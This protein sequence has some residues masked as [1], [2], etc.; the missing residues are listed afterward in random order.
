MSLN[1]L[2]QSLAPLW[3]KLPP[4]PV[5]LIQTEN[6]G[7]F[8]MSKGSYWQIYEK[9]WALN[10]WFVP[11]DN[12]A[13]VDAIKAAMYD[14]INASGVNVTVLTHH[15]YHAGLQMRYGQGFWLG[16]GK[17]YDP[18]VHH[19]LFRIQRL[20]NVYFLDKGCVAAE[21][22]PNLN[23]Y[24]KLRYTQL[25]GNGACGLD[26]HFLCQIS[27]PKSTTPPVLNTTTAPIINTTQT[28]FTTA[29]TTVPASTTTRFD[30]HLFHGLVMLNAIILLTVLALFVSN[31]MTELRRGHR[32]AEEKKKNQ[33][34]K[35]KNKV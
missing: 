22:R 34:H 30:F 17:A 29:S 33:K 11:L 27:H 5:P 12:Q 21:Y 2:R 1:G 25:P 13:L 28:T 6:F 35:K 8:V 16:S 31:K 20:S 4:C 19:K 23:A 9:C 15:I 18:D 24:N 32:C 10:G 26:R 7:N 3:Y 14:C